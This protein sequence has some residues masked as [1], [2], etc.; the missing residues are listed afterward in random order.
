MGLHRSDPTAAPPHGACFSR[1]YHNAD[2]LHAATQLLPSQ[3]STAISV[4]PHAPL[5]AETPSNKLR[6][7]SSGQARRFRVSRQYHCRCATF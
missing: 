7:R 6:Q 1:D 3:A 4:Q 2:L 5:N